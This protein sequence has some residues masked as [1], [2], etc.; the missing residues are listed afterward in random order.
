LFDTRWAEIKIEGKNIFSRSNHTS[1]VF[2][3]YLFIHGG[4]DVDK[5]ILSDFNSIDL[6]EN[7]EEY[8][9]KKLNNTCDGK[10]IKLKSH[11]AVVYKE[12]M[13]LFGGEIHTN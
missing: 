6:S 1:A 13:V 9:W 11:T 7:C 3:S 8:S 2:D 4:Y 12:N 10:E 5:G